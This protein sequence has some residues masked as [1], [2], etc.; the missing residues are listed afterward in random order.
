MSSRRLSPDLDPK[1][2]VCD[3]SSVLIEA[4]LNPVDEAIKAKFSTYL[5]L[6][7]RWNARI[8][9]TA[10]RDAT[11]IVR[12][13]FI[14]SIACAQALP[15]GI[16]SLLDFGSGAGFPGIPIALCR[17][18]IDVTLAEARAKKAAFL[19]ETVRTLQVKCR[20]WPR[21]GE[22][23]GERFD[24]VTLRAVD[25]MDRAMAVSAGLVSPDGW[26]VVLTTASDMDEIRT[27][28]GGGF[29]WQAGI[30]L[31]GSR[32]QLIRMARRSASRGD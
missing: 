22:E 32:Q 12:R 14:E 29:D 11:G 20:V 25:R 16:R 13:H 19:Q 17:P 3:L 7:I 15:T 23:I 30:S 31:P 5:D 6:L 27:W 21:R 10:V 1:T 26:L 28:V 24:C 2:A 18:K 8:N 4:G 9:L